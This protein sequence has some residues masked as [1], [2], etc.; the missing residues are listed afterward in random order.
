MSAAR[1]T[2]GKQVARRAD[3]MGAKELNHCRVRVLA[4]RAYLSLAC[5]VN[6]K[7]ELEYSYADDRFGISETTRSGTGKRDGSSGK[8]RSDSSCR[9]RGSCYSAESHR[10]SAAGRWSCSRAGGGRSRERRRRRH[11]GF[12][13]RTLLWLGD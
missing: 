11:S 12:C 8:P 9:Y 6:R 2:A 4:T 10:K 13:R 3:L 5:E 7:F 1:A